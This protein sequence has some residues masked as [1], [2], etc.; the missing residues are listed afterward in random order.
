MDLT[1]REFFIFLPMLFLN[2][3]FGIYPNAV[4]HYTYLSMLK[5]LI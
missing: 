1:K 4:F 2:F 3:F 5:V